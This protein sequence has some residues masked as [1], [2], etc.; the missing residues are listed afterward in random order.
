MNTIV[1]LD[2]R[3]VLD[4][5]LRE[6]EHIHRGIIVIGSWFMDEETR[7]SQ[8]CM[9]LMDANPARGRK[10]VPCIIALDQMW[11]WTREV[12]DPEHVAEQIGRWISSG[13][14]PGS[15]SNRKDVQRVFDAVQSRLRDIVAMPPM[16]ISGAIK[17]EVSPSTV[18]E[19]VMRDTRSGEVLNQVEVTANVRD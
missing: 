7:R 15:P 14:M 5:R 8:P 9:V 16:P 4:L 6:F 11:L 1:N 17:H 3:P 18:G 13:A 2:R 12:G 19:I 10:P